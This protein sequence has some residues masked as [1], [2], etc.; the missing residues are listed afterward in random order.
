MA[1]ANPPGGRK[2]ARSWRRRGGGGGH[3]GPMGIH[4]PPGAGAGG[5][6]GEGGANRFQVPGRGDGGLGPVREWRHDV[7]RWR[8]PAG[9]C[10]VGVRG[11]GPGFAGSR[12]R[13]IDGGELVAGGPNL[14][15]ESRRWAASRSIGGGREFWEVEESHSHFRKLRRASRRRCAGLSGR[16]LAGGRRGRMS[17]DRV[18]RVLQDV[19]GSILLRQEFADLWKAG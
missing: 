10:S 13:L 14:E 15:G 9:R 8:E 6:K 5:P 2:C 17:G 19:G 18:W 16:G 7:L 11:R 1:E 12:S 3:S 4:W